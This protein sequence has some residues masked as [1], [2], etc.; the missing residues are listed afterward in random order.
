[1]LDRQVCYALANLRC[2]SA[3]FPLMEAEID[4]KLRLSV[5]LKTRSDE[6]KS[7]S[8]THRTCA[9]LGGTFGGT[10]S[11]VGTSHRVPERSYLRR[12]K[13]YPLR[14]VAPPCAREQDRENLNH[15]PA[16]RSPSRHRAH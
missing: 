11:R 5:Q 6:N 16:C 15:T 1:M 13:R 2:F 8:H 7:Q 12:K 10:K 14:A 4:D 3:N 9:L